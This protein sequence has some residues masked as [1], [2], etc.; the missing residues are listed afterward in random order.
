MDL[1]IHSTCSDGSLTP[2]EIVKK[3]SEKK[4]KI[5]SITDHDEISAYKLAKPKADKLDI[6]LIPGVEI[7]TEVNK[8]EVHILGYFIDVNNKYLIEGLEKLREQRELRVKKIS[9]KLTHLGYP[10]TYDEVCQV[11]QGKSIGRV[12]VAEA[13]IKKGYVSSIREAFNSFLATSEKAYVPRYKLSPNQAIKLI[14]KA[15]GVAVL[16]H[17]VQIQDDQLVTE[18]TKFVDGIEVYHSDHSSEDIKK[19]LSYAEKS[20]L[21]VSGGSDCH[22]SSKG[23]PFLMGTV[24]IPE[25][26]KI[27]WKLG[28]EELLSPSLE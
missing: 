28:K 26:V 7:N 10:L 6:K 19:Y 23:M 8:K 14:H 25:S 5:I 21:I 11:S 2:E 18:L 12:H 22:G 24:L 9:E 13:M 17:P 1:H 20:S 16:A 3:A 15:G 4:L 27:P